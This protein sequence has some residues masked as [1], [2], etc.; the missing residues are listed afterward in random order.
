MNTKRVFLHFSKWLGFFY[1]SRTFHRRGLR[2]LCYHGFA[3]NDECDFRP[4]LFICPRTFERRLRYLSSK[5]FPV[6]GLEEGLE[7]L[8]A[9]RLP[10]GATAITID[11]G[12]YSF[13]R[14]AV[15][16]L[17]TYSYPATVNMTT[18]HC[19]KET[20]VFRLIIQY[21]FWKTSMH[22]LDMDLC[23]TP[24][25]GR[26]SWKNEKEKYLV[27]WETIR[28]GEAEL[29]ETQRCELARGIGK[30]L[31]VDYDPIARQRTLNLLTPSELRELVRAG[32]DLQLHTHRHRL[33]EDELS[34]RREIADN[35]AVL[36]PIVGKRL[37]HLCYPSED[38]SENSWSWLAAAGVK[39]A[40]T[41]APGPNFSETVRFGLT[42]FLDSENIN[43][44]EFESEMSG[45]N[46]LLRGIRASLRR[47]IALT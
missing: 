43:Q 2:I 45:F 1:L 47:R 29:N 40:A 3:M 33:P 21:M 4:K 9:D 36:E 6:V 26:V 27:M 5:R 42:R 17:R 39:S 16:L 46:D 12:F 41:C 30:R 19:V 37:E 23:A 25:I 8:W 38:W 20:P 34:I 24:S 15:P 10:E 18:Y 22:E 44:I 14:C 32:F 35:R 13:L 31:Q 7:M 28:F 11:D